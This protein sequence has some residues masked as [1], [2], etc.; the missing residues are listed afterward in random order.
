MLSPAEFTIANLFATFLRF[1]T[2][3]AANGRAFSTSAHI[4]LNVERGRNVLLRHSV[5][6]YKTLMLILVFIL[7][8]LKRI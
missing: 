8:F 1:T 3:P 6:H 7:L 4:V 5:K 2:H